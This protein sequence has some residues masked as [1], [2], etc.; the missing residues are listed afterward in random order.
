MIYKVGHAEVDTSTREI[1]QSG[2]SRL[3]EPR[4]FD[5][6]EYLIRFRHR[7]VCKQVLIGRSEELNVAA[8]CVDDVLRGEP[9]TLVVSGEAGIGKTAFCE[10]V[11]EMAQ[12]RGV[13]S[14][15]GKCSEVPGA[16]AYWPFIQLLRGTLAAE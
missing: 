8:A 3:A 11:A 14:F 7:M 15:W 1:R 6:V 12:A 9:R 10:R 5:F 2:M 13:V 4:V 16:P